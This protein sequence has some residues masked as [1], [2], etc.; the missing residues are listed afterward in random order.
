[1]NIINL[2]YIFI[3]IISVVLHEVAHG[4][5]ADALGDPTARI[6]GRLT[7]NPISH[8]DPIGSIVVPFLL[9]ITGAPFMLGWAKP[10]PFNP[11]NLRNK[12]WGGAL[13]ALAGPAI[14]IFL[15]IIFGLLIQLLPVSVALG[16]FFSVIV[17]TNVAL[18]VFN[19]V[20]IPPLDGHHILFALLP[21]SLVKVKGFLQKY[22]FVFVLVF[23]I[24]GWRI[25]QPIIMKVYDIL[26]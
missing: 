3:L 20:P 5:A 16:N 24:Y 9:F 8:I 18:A 19:L 17:L 11:Y 13:V 26:V 12:K 25:I 22:G 10:V 21:K 7:L 6:K 15:A 23:I 14:N 2:V 1:M 4:Y